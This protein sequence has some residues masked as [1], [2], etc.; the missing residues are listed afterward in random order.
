MSLTFFVPTFNSESTINNTLSN[1]ELA[2]S[3]LNNF[4]Y[5]VL[6]I[7]DYSTTNSFD[8][9]KK[10]SKNYQNVKVIK[11]EFNL[12]FCK[13]FM[14]GID[15]CNNEFL[16]FLPA[17]NVINYDQIQKIIKEYDKQDMLIVNYSNQIES[18]EISRVLISKIFSLSVNLFFLNK[19]KYF[20]GTNIYKT[21]F[22]KKIKIRSNSFIFQ[23]EIVL[24]MMKM[25]DKFKECSV[26]LN[27]IKSKNTSFFYIENIISNSI[28]FV[29]LI[30]RKLF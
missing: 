20:N 27:N 6:I 19:I 9:L 21:E 16:M 28:D 30:I 25:T 14:K 10:I 13:N 1:I 8:I 5:E 15:N 23:A 7:D 3:G 11:N 26:K 22:L 29:K 18:R 4:E 24:K 12:G 2:I 17:G